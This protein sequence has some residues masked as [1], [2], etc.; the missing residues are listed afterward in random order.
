MLCYMLP[1]NPKEKNSVI[2]F[3]NQLLAE[4]LLENLPEMNNFRI[5]SYCFIILIYILSYQ[6]F[7]TYH[8]CIQVFNPFLY[9]N[10]NL[11]YCIGEIIK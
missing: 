6:V 10:N 11:N 4:K 2:S 5:W 8:L 9:F 1:S 7:H 3:E